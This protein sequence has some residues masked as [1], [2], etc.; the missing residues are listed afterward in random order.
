MKNDN[1]SVIARFVAMFVVIIN[2][3][4]TCYGKNPIPFSE[5]EVFIAASVIIAFIG[6]AYMSWKN[7]SFTEPAKMGDMVMNAIKQG[8]IEARTVEELIKQKGDDVNDI[9]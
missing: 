5:N 6:S 1:T 7:N 9:N 8:V 3:I 2:M 4:L